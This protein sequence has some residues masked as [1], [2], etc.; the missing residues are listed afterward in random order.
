[1]SGLGPAALVVNTASRRGADA[2]PAAREHF[3]GTAFE[4][5][6][7]LTGGA[8]DDLADVGLAGSAN[9]GLA[10]ARASPSQALSD[11]VGGAPVGAFFPLVPGHSMGCGGAPRCPTDARRR[12]QN[13]EEARGAGAF[14]VSERGLDPPEGPSAWFPA[15]MTRSPGVARLLRSPVW[16]R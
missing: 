14:P 6:L 9:I 1:V 15:V 13:E 5:A 7:A 4:V 3:P 16:G 12:P 8:V 2:F 11:L 10:T